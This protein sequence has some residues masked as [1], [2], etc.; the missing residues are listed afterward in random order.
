MQPLEN[1]LFLSVPICLNKFGGENAEYMGLFPSIC[2]A[3]CGIA[4]CACCG[5]LNGSLS[6]YLRIVPFIVTLGMMQIV[7]DVAKWV[8]REEMVWPP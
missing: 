8:A 2:A 3:L 1:R 6:G 5:L 7:R 4:A